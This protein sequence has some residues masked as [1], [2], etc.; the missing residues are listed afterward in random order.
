MAIIGGSTLVALINLYLFT[1]VEKLQREIAL[2]YR[3]VYLMALTIPAISVSGIVSASL[4]KARD[5]RGLLRAGKSRGEVQALILENVDPTKPNWW[6]LGGS[7]VFV[8]F[9]LAM[10]L[11]I[12]P[13]MKT[14]RRLH[15]HR[16]L[17]DGASD[18][19]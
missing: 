17:S 14:I 11:A 9:T 7:L 1:G 10:G 3:N 2:V 4:L 8:V 18:T 15:G 5:R 13:T 19:S 16:Q 12:C 6:I